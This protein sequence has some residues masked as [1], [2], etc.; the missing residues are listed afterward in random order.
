MQLFGYMSFSCLFKYIGMICCQ[1][2]L[3]DGGDPNQLTST[4]RILFY[5]LVFYR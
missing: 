1:L 5:G 3:R 4:D 2:T